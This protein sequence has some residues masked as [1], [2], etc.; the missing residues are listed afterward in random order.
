MKFSFPRRLLLTAVAVLLLG[1]A[2]PGVASAGSYE[3]IA[4][5]GT[6]TPGATR[7]TALDCDDCTT[8]LTLPFAVQVYGNTYTSVVVSSNGNIQF[9][10]NRTTFTNT[11]LPATSFAQTFFGYWDDLELRTAADRAGP[12]AGV[13]TSVV[14]TAPNR[15]FII[16]FRAFH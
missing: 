12:T 2:Y 9:A 8:T 6:I 15:Q 10:S 14:G 7:V 16:E 4:T 11:C 3:I 5:T 13:F 1:A